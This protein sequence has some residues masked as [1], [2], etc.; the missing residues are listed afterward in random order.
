MGRSLGLDD[1]GGEN[2]GGAPPVSSM[3][4]HTLWVQVNPPLFLLLVRG[5]V[6][7]AGLSNTSLRSV[8]LV[9]GILGAAGMLL[10]A[11]RVIS[12]ALAALAC[13]LLALHPTAIEY[14][15]TL[16]QYSGEL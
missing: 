10:S 3:F 15:H 2:S 11:R 13:A 8:P 7:L 5:A 12:P 9:L 14:S 6:D 1:G 4:F 16:K